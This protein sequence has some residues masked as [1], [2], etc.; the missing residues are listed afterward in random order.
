MNLV[1]RISCRYWVWY[2]IKVLILQ[3]TCSLFDI[4]WCIS[5]CSLNIFEILSKIYNQCVVLITNMLIN[6]DE[7]L[8]IIT[9]RLPG[10][11][12]PIKFV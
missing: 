8:V 1:G 3:Q 11:D 4:I 10:T 5:F 7:I 2:T 6:A 12:V 9:R